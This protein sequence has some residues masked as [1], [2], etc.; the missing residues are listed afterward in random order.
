MNI[1]VCIRRLA[2]GELNPFDACAYE[3]A[4]R[5]NDAEVT[6]LSMGPESVKEQ[7]SSVQ[8]FLKNE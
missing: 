2:N 6:L 7:I 5:I 1:T 3:A 4:L 8:E